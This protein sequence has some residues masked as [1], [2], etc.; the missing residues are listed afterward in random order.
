MASGNTTIVANTVTQGINR[1]NG[2]RKPA[3]F[4][5]GSYTFTKHISR[6]STA[7]RVVVASP[8]QSSRQSTAVTFAVVIA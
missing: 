4:R 7:V 1:H 8:D 3:V 5:T 6:Q 2:S